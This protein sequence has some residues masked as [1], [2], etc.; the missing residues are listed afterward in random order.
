[1]PKV[2]HIFSQRSGWAKGLLL[3]FSKS[4]RFQ[5]SAESQS[6]SSNGCNTIFSQLL[7]FQP[8]QVLPHYISFQLLR[9]FLEL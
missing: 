6:T 4:R 5:I 8:L 3:D 7:H 1:M 2:L 9:S